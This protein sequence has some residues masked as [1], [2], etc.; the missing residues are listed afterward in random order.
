MAEPASELLGES[1]LVKLSRRRSR[2]LRISPLSVLRTGN[3]HWHCMPLLALT[4]ASSLALRDDQDWGSGSADGRSVAVW[5]WM[6]PG[7]CSGLRADQCRRAESLGQKIELVT[8]DDQ[9]KP[10]QSATAV[11]KLIT[12]DKVVAILGDATSS[13][14]LEAAPI[15][16]SR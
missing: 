5:H 12:Q 6:P 11:R 16:Q 7:I 13:A 10:G 1:C 9:S 2:R 4:L 3:C 15:A 8:E 14:T